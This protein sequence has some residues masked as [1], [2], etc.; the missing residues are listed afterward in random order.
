M[1]ITSERQR[2]RVALLIA[3]NV[4]ILVAYAVYILA[5]ISTP[6]PLLISVLIAGLG[7]NLAELWLSTPYRDETRR[8]SHKAR[9]VR[10]AVARAL[11]AESGPFVLGRMT[12]S[13]VNARR[14]AAERV[15][16]AERLTALEEGRTPGQRI[17]PSF[18][19]IEETIL[20]AEL[21]QADLND[22]TPLI[23]LTD[24]TQLE[25]T[26]PEA[27]QPETGQSDS[28]LM[29]TVSKQVVSGG[30][31]Q[32][33][34]APEHGTP[35]AVQA[36]DAQAPHNASIRVDEATAAARAFV[37][38]LRIPVEIPHN[39]HSAL[40]VE[41]VEAEIQTAAPIVDVAELENIL[42]AVE[43]EGEAAATM[44]ALEQL[45]SVVLGQANT[46]R[47]TQPLIP[48]VAPEL[49]ELQEEIR[50]GEP[51]GPT[52]ASDLTGLVPI[53]EPVAM[54]IDSS[55]IDVVGSEVVT[56]AMLADLTVAEPTS[57][58]AVSVEATPSGQEVVEAEA[59]IPSLVVEELPLA[60]VEVETSL[61]VELIPE[62]GLAQAEAIVAEEVV[63]SDLTAPLETPTWG[64]TAA[65]AALAVTVAATRVIGLGAD[66]IGEDNEG[67]VDIA[68]AKP[69]AAVGDEL[70]KR[71]EANLSGEKPGR[72]ASPISHV[73]GRLRDP[74]DVV[75]AT[76]LTDP[77]RKPATNMRLRAGVSTPSIPVPPRAATGLRASD[78]TLALLRS[79]LG[80]GKDAEA[81]SARR[82]RVE[83]DQEKPA[84]S[85]PESATSNPSDTTHKTL[86]SAPKRPSSQVSDSARDRVMFVWHGRHFL[87]PMEVRHP[88]RVAQSLYDF[89]VEEAMERG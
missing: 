53:V 1:P 86:R 64:T 34:G 51:R 13:A 52:P 6:S 29:A 39:E 83:A 74:V 69:A 48:E 78:E 20:G 7:Y 67:A 4:L 41:I 77:I 47:S 54:S 9:T 76:L 60:T 5:S 71:V 2:N 22:E 55:Q 19:P 45:G 61:P 44:D 28:A 89:M 36:R 15:S 88:L 82:A 46:A 58:E 17:E 16:L 24:P 37:N 68:A 8:T 87:P 85:P 35:E 49:A 84:G 11:P 10:R 73:G 50:I 75:I 31:E 43:A 30:P 25:A 23:M 66:L 12:P 21:A 81:E 18:T 3:L 56:A 59:T 14:G 26:Q 40:T 57:V 32:A 33:A 70:E 42:E 38:A 62:S 80:V 27:A 65:G 63:A 79:Q 72:V